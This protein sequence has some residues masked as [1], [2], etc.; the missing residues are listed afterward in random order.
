MSFVSVAQAKPAVVNDSTHIT[1]LFDK[2]LTNKKKSKKNTKMTKIPTSSNPIEEFKNTNESIAAKNDEISLNA[3]IPVT[4]EKISRL[5]VTPEVIS[6]KIDFSAV[7]E[8]SAI[9][10]H[11]VEVIL[12]TIIL[13]TL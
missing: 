10:G 9:L 11:R 3:T 8:P 6:A 12:K 2:A 7:V 4:A 5:N 1:S 13:L